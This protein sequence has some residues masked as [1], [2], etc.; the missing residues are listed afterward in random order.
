MQRI[1]IGDGGGPI[2]ARIETPIDFFFIRGTAPPTTITVQP[3]INDVDV[4]VVDVTNF[5]VDS[6]LGIFDVA[7]DRFYFGT[8]LAINA[9]TLTL[10]TPLDFA[11][12]VGNNVQ[13][14]SRDLNVDG[15]TTPVTFQIR[16]SGPSSNLAVNITRFMFSMECATRLNLNDFGD[17]DQLSNGLVFRR[18]NGVTRNI[19]NIKRNSDFITLAY[20]LQLFDAT[21][22][23]QGVN[24]LAS[25][26]TF[27]GEDKH[28]T[29]LQLLPG[30]SLDLIVQD[31]LSGLSLFRVMGQGYEGRVCCT[32]QVIEIPADNKPHQVA[33][34][35]VKGFIHTVKTRAELT[36]LQ[37]YRKTGDPAPTDFSDSIQWVPSQGGIPIN[38][39]TGIDVYIGVVGDI[40]GEIRLDI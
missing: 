18:T 13:P 27:N 16:G 29:V 32:P 37:T 24:G 3:A 31:D 33:F 28:G 25:R 2:D 35:I 23:A 21:N 20:D 19:F 39:S 22:P 30:D 34:N 12:N 8:V 10:D 4:Q 1:Q 38:T 36:Y 26:Y 40:P 6:F 9:N 11:F 14:L 17:L 7:Q 5:S 15:S